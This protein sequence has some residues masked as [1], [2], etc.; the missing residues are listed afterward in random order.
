MKFKVGDKVS[1]KKKFSKEEV[2]NYALTCND[3]N[4]IHLDEDFVSKTVFKKNI[5]HGMLTASLFGGLL[6]TTLPGQGTVHLGQ[7]LKF[8]KPV[9]VEEMIEAIIEIIKIRED[10]PIL[11]FRTYVVNSLG[12]VVLDGEAVI[13]YYEQ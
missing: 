8:L 5:V 9:F 2:L 4:P 1:Y 7:S 3:Q 11:T 10:K 6:G 12:E 13:K